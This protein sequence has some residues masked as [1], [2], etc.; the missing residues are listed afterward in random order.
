MLKETFFFGAS[1]LENFNW[2]K[3]SGGM[4]PTM[5]VRIKILKNFSVQR[6]TLFVSDLSVRLV[7]RRP[8]FDSL[9]ESG[10][11]TLKFGIHSFPA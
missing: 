9:P 11:K 3:Y 10:Q 6:S 1:Y 8:E 2:P 5:L 4:E 7:V